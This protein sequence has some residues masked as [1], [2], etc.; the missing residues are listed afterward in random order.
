MGGTRCYALRVRL[1]GDGAGEHGPSISAV[2]PAEHGQGEERHSG[3]GR[4][5]PDGSVGQ[6]RA[7]EEVR[8][9][10]EGQERVPLR[11]LAVGSGVPGEGGDDA[12]ASGRGVW[13]CARE[14]GREVTRWRWW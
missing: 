5:D 2:E 14:R 13:C 3:A 4:R 10:D 7:F 12:G 6:P 8:Q 1:G 11:L 9:D